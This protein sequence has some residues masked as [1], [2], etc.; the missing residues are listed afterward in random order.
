M[1]TLKNAYEIIGTI[2]RHGSQHIT[3]YLGI[4]NIGWKRILDFF[5][6]VPGSN[7]K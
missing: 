6:N 1:I 5:L 4:L 2:K 3:T 7:Y